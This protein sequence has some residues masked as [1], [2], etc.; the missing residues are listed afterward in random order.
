[1]AAYDSHVAGYIV[2]SNSPDRYRDLGNMLDYYLMIVS[3]AP[4]A[5][6]A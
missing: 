1:M 6:S 3:P 5:A 4:A 2:K